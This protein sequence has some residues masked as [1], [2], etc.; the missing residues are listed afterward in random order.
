MAANG[1]L[2]SC[3][4]KERGSK[5]PNG[6][7]GRKI[8]GAL[9]TKSC[10][11]KK[12]SNLSKMSA[13]TPLCSYKPITK[14]LNKN[15]A[16]LISLTTFFSG[17]SFLTIT[18]SSVTLIT[19][20]SAIILIQARALGLTH[21]TENCCKQPLYMSCKTSRAEGSAAVTPIRTATV[22]KSLKLTIAA[23]ALTRMKFRIREW[24]YMSVQRK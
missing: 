5:P 24:F 23:A 9:A 11:C 7:S 2:T 13:A 17:S 3:G 20:L 22:I 4:W 12:S 14:S 8:S 21:D 6:P 1:T 19:F 10:D 15:F 16:K 18:R